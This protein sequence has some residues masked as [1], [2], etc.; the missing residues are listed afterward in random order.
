MRVHLPTSH[1]IRRTA[2]VIAAAAIALAMLGN[3]ALAAPPVVRDHIASTGAAATNTVCV[4]TV[5][6]TTS[7]FAI[8]DNPDGPAQACLDISRYDKTE[9]G[10]V[11]LG[12]ETGCS[13]FAPS[14]FSIDAKGL[15]TASLAP[16]A[17]VVQA[18]MCDSTGCNPAGTRTALVSATYAGAGD[19]A[20]FRSNSKST[21]GGCTM[22]FVGKGSSR[23][24]T[25]NLTIDGRS[26][27]A[28]GSLFTSTQKL[29]VLC[30]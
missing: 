13:L 30:H 14:S 7:L 4:G 3:G 5:C 27:D 29:K 16:T 1:L 12:Y 6:T 21:F 26:L 20:T 19:L 24:A 9:M 23:E 8:V 28:L 18:F 2:T 17:I 22:Y 25:A 11:P 15:T 10:F